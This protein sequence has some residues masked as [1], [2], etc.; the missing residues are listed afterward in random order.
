ME[1]WSPVPV[2][3]WAVLQVLVF[4]GSFLLFIEGCLVVAAVL[5]GIGFVDILTYEPVTLKQF[6]HR[7]DVTHS[8]RWDERERRDDEASYRR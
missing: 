6:A 8:E 2:I 5:F 1:L 3:V 7:M 4:P